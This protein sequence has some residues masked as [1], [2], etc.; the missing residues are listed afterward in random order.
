MTKH[1]H[2]KLFESNL[3]LHCTNVLV[4]NDFIKFD[5]VR[6]KFVFYF[7]IQKPDWILYSS[8]CVFVQTSANVCIDIPPT[9]NVIPILMDV[10]IELQHSI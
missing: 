1:F 5:K 2:P 6:E 3:E 4:H 9:L 8:T 10:I 7:L